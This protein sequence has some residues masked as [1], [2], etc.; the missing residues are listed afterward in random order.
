MEV[1]HTP[2]EGAFVSIPVPRTRDSVRPP[3]DSFLNAPIGSF[4]GVNSLSRFA[5]SYQRA[6][7]FKSIEPR[8]KVSRSYF[9][10]DEELYDP[11]TLAPNS[12]GRKL[13]TV[14]NPEQLTSFAPYYDDEQAVDDMSFA[15]QSY[16]AISRAPSLISY[17]TANHIAD[18]STPLVLKKV[19]DANGNLVTVIAGQSTAP[20][21]V[22]NSVNVLIGV[23][24]LALPLGLSHAGWVLGVIILCLCAI[25][26]FWTAKLLS[27]CM[28]TDQTLM[29]YAD[30][31]YAAFG[32]KARL[33][34]SVLFSLDLLGA[35]V[36]LIVLFS[37]S[38]NALFPQISVNQFKAIAFCVL[39]PFSF[40]PLRVLSSISLL[41]I[42]CTLSVILTILVLGLVKQDSPGS[43][44]Q[45]MPT[46]LYP[47]SVN[48]ILIALG[49]LM[50]PFG[51]HAI[52][53]NLKV[54]MRHPLKFE[55]CLKTTYAITFMADFSMACIGFL[56]FGNAVHDEVTHSVL[57]TPGYPAF[58]YGLISALVSCVPLAKTPLNAG[59]I[60]SIIEFV[61]GLKDSPQNSSFGTGILKALVKI[62]VNLLF[63]VTSV[64]FPKFDKIIGVLGASVCSLV[65]LILP[66]SFYLKICQPTSRRER[67]LCV[68]TIVVASV[69]GVLGTIAAISF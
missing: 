39:T 35:G 10:D 28:D 16:H 52:F 15:E 24:L 40:M 61:L 7:S 30:L 68:F 69:L 23:G 32:P 50:G 20:Q 34:I 46:N 14:F 42:A 37:D 8:F 51:G 41:G 56:M 60:I 18:E 45:F 6:Q 33:M 47:R 31:G 13:S 55:S 5:S 36:S 48:D 49:I 26:T 57:I 53:P 63:V 44:Q 67:A 62:G 3:R 11:D 38:L 9:K 59:P 65:C 1:P 4:R 58:V 64:A 27:K 19:E 66:C 12:L 25:S 54:D 22:F 2:P 29:T 17:A 43:L 21:T